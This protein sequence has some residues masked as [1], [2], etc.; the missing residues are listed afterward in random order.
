MSLLPPV[1]VGPI[2][3]CSSSI[4]VQGQLV[5][6]TVNLFS[7]GNNVGSGVATWADQVFPLKGG[8]TLTP[9]ANISATQTSDGQTSPK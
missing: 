7:N 8:V 9:G 4:R 3:E 5:G 6:A 2:S 1:V